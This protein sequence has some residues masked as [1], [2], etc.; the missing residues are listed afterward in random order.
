MSKIIAWIFSQ[1]KVGKLLDGKKTIIGAVLILASAL[2]QALL[3]IAP[4]FP[5]HIWLGD[6]TQQLS[7]VLRQV[8]PILEDLGIA[9]IGVGLAHKA[10]KNRN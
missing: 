9:T 2:L 7:S 6:V 1:T 5:E 4:M 3:V 10:V 8:Q